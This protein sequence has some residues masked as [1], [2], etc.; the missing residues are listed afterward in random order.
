MKRH[1]RIIAPAI[2]A[3]ASGL[4][5]PAAIAAGH[6]AAAKPDAA[7]T[8][9][10]AQGQ[11]QARKE[12][13]RI[14]EEAVSALAKTEQALRALEAGHKKQAIDLLA[15]ATGKL[16]ILTAAHPDLALA[17]VGVQVIVRDFPGDAKAI[18]A[19]VKQAEDWLED[20]EVQKARHQ[21]ET[22]ASEIDVRVRNLPLATWPDAI[23]AIAPLIEKGKT[24]EALARL[25][26]ALSTV[27]VVDHITPIPLIHAGKLLARAKAMV[28][29]KKELS[30]AQSNKVHELLQAARMEIERARAL[31][32]IGKKDARAMLD[33]VR[34]L[35]R[36]SKSGHHGLLDAFRDTI[37]KLIE[38][39][40]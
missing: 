17:P 39:V 1:L 26:Q 35:E 2:F 12:R 40:K 30:E 38:K 11:A 10:K 24:N 20:G 6:A 7:H 8:E 36:Q 3:L 28:G 29:K 37:G 15:E 31:G 33:D 21:L 23:K 18:E 16:E 9:A 34:K 14:I 22:L 19:A 27:V 32:Y 13:S 5:A 25:Q 4:Q